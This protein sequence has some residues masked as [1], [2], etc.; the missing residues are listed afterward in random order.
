MMGYA[1]TGEDLARGDELRGV[2]RTGDIGYL[3][4]E[5]FLFLVGRSKRIAKIFGLRI[6]LDEVEAILRQG[7]PAAIVG[8]RDVIWGFCEFGTD[9]SLAVLAQ[10]IAREFRIHHSSLRLRRVDGIPTLSS[11]KVDYQQIEQWVAS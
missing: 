11:G 9:E 7:G 6:N 4:D 8:G 1:S 5:G 3:D 2:L 10:S